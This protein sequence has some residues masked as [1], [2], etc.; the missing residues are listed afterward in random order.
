MK[1]ALSFVLSVYTN[2]ENEGRADTFCE[3][4]LIRPARHLCPFIGYLQG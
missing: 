1:K 2:S 3:V 4:F